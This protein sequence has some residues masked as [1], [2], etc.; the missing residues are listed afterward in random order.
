VA[1]WATAISPGP[2]SESSQA[3][4]F[5]V[6]TDNPGLFASPPSVAPNGT[7]TFAP[8]ANAYGSAT[9]SVVA[10]DD[11]G[12]AAGGVDSSG[13]AT[14]TIAIQAVN[15]AP[16]C[17]I[18]GN[19]TVLSLLGAQSVSGFASGMPGPANESGQQVTFV[20]TTDKPGLFIVQPSI[21]PAGT[22][23]YRPRV[24]GLGVATV[25]VRAVDDGGTA[26]GGSDTSAPTSFTITII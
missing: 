5:T 21:S 25:T 14:F 24:L 18:G 26:N 1:G 2:A 17:S 19:Q 3:V 20:V 16:T 7:L 22:L 4:G 23:T 6:T 11:G 13:T 10:R 8:A 9:V 12:T 15:D